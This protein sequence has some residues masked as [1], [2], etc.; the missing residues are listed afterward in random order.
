[1]ASSVPEQVAGPP[2]PN[3]QPDRAPYDA[4]RA[5]AGRLAEPPGGL[6]PANQPPPK[7]AGASPPGPA[8]AMQVLGCYL[9][10]EQPPD[11]LLVIDYGRADRVVPAEL[12]AGARR[13]WAGVDGCGAALERDGCLRYAGCD[14]VYCEGPQGH[15]WPA[16]ATARIWRFFRAHPRRS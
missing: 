5:T 14:L 11:E 4:G 10:V 8:R 6:F 2:A 13:W 16:D 9:V 1:M 3:R 15:R 7:S 12:I